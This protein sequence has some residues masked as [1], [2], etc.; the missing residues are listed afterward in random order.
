MKDI[1]SKGREQCH[2]DRHNLDEE[3]EGQSAR[4]MHWSVLYQTVALE[5]KELEAAAFLRIKQ[6]PALYGIVGSGSVDAVKS[7]VAL[8]EDVK[9]KRREVAELESIKTS[10]EHRRTMLRLLGDL[11]LGG[12]Y[13]EVDV[14]EELPTT[15]RRRQK[16]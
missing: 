10:F 12:Y 11:W 13:G 9:E 4:F 16:A 14:R 15:R 7:A 6:E 2:I 8:V 3:A 1:I 5:L